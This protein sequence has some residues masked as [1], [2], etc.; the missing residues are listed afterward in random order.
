MPCIKPLNN[1]CK[2][3][4]V[5]FWVANKNMKEPCIVKKIEQL[6]EVLES[7]FCFY[8]SRYSLSIDIVNPLCYTNG[9]AT[10]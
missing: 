5:V 1:A 4:W 7:I 8:I 10:R 3:S 9:R 2:T 6:N